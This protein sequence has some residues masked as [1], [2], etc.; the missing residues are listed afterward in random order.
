MIAV[1]R[2]LCT[3]PTAAGTKDLILRMLAAMSGGRPAVATARL[4]PNDHELVCAHLASARR[5]FAD[6]QAT[7]KLDKPK[8]G[9][10]EPKWVK[11]HTTIRSQLAV[12]A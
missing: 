8:P 2:D 12:E 7:Q 4:L 9:N 6:A 5:S 10:N 3:T 1:R 11:H